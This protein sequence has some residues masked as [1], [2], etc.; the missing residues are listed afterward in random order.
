MLKTPT[1]GPSLST[2]TS[3]GIARRRLAPSITTTISSA[4]GVFLPIPASLRASMI[5]ASS[6]MARAVVAA[7]DAM[8]VIGWSAPSRRTCGNQDIHSHSAVRVVSV[9]SVKVTSFGLCSVASC[10][11][12][13]FAS[14]RASSSG[15]AMPITPR[16][17]RRMRTGTSVASHA[18]VRLC[19]SCSGSSMVTSD[20]CVAVPTRTSRWSGS[21][22]R[23]SHRRG[24]GV[25][26]VS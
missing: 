10:A 1:A 17:A 25:T 3:D 22:R 12:T 6:A 4:G 14:L 23:R 13:Q 2:C 5:A 24:S 8:L 26:A 9:S 19:D 11:T 16:S 20:R 21:V 7:F 15:P 18:T